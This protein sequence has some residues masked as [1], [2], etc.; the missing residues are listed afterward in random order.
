MLP[1]DG[2]KKRHMMYYWT[3]ESY[4]KSRETIPEI[5]LV[6]SE[7]LKLM[8]DKINKINEISTSLYSFIGSTVNEVLTRQEIVLRTKTVYVSK[9]NTKSGHN[10]CKSLKH[11]RT[12]SGSRGPR[13]VLKLG[14]R[15]GINRGKIDST[16]K[17]KMAHCA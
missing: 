10:V 17:S 12:A 7:V 15:G 9:Q 4:F 6:Y 13:F 14:P 5:L 1:P 16:I 2:K 8:S 3:K 11:K